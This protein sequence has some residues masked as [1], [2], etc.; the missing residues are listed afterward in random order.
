MS[1]DNEI[2]ITGRVFADPE[3]RGAVVNMR[4]SVNSYRK[5]K[6][7]RPD[8]RY[9]NET[10]WFRC[11]FFRKLHDAARQFRKG[12]IVT[13]TG[14]LELGSYWSEKDQR[15]VP[16]VEIHAESIDYAERNAPMNGG[17]PRE[18]SPA[19]GSRAPQAPQS[20]ADPSFFDDSEGVPF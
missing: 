14:S 2:R 18:R 8:D 13:I 1:R 7:A 3:T 20:N 4:V 9:P 6:D 16:T 5:K 15:D 12:D 17:P 19:A 11:I 10:N